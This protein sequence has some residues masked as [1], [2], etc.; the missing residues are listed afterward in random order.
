MP[1]LLLLPGMDGTGDLFDAFVAALPATLDVVTVRYPARE[2]LG[3]AEL[4]ALAR[5]AMPEKGPFVI[6]GE[7]FSGPIAISLAAASTSITQ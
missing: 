4:Q 1:T 5:A 7:S 3:Y 2:P 6:L